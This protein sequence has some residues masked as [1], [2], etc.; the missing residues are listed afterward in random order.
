MDRRYLKCNLTG[1]QK[2]NFFLRSLLLSAPT[3]ELHDYL[4]CSNN[5][6]KNYNS[7]EFL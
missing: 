6:Q 4:S 1:M 7:A 3:S 2:I 5:D